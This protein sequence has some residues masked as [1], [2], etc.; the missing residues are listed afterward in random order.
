MTWTPQFTRPTRAGLLIVA[1]SCISPLQAQDRAPIIDMHM[2]AMGAN[3]QG[4]G[5]AC[6][7]HA[8]DQARCA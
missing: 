2:H 7:R 8:L 4:P 1:S 3:D 6:A 5:Y